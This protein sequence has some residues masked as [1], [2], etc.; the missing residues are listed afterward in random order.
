MHSPML[1]SDLLT[2]REAASLL[3]VSPSRVRHLVMDG[4]LPAIKRGRDLWIQRA[5]LDLVENRGVP[6]YPK[7]R[8]RTKEVV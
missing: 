2:T 1:G 7:G 5:D 8:P 6:G 3:G 4:R